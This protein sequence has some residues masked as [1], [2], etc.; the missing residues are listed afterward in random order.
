M[1]PTVHG[2]GGCGVLP[3]RF[4]M[5][6]IPPAMTCYDWGYL[7]AIGCF[8]DA[9]RDGS[10]TLIFGDEFQSLFKSL[11]DIGVG[12]DPTKEEM[13]FDNDLKV[14]FEEFQLWLQRI[15]RKTKSTRAVEGCVETSSE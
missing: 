14:S 7:Q 8:Q 5:T 10:D 4:S 6:M 15:G 9:D 2:K 11:A 12:S 1:T 13:D 3:E